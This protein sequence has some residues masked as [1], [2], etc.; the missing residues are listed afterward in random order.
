MRPQRLLSQLLLLLQPAIYVHLAAAL[1]HSIAD[2]SN[3][4][5]LQQQEDLLH[6]RRNEA[7][8][9]CHLKQINTY[10]RNNKANHVNSKDTNPGLRPSSRADGQQGP[11]WPS[12]FPVPWLPQLAVCKAEQ[13]QH[14]LVL[15]QLGVNRLA[16]VLLRFFGLLHS[17]LHLPVLLRRLRELQQPARGSSN[18][19]SSSS[20]SSSSNKSSSKSSNGWWPV[21]LQWDTTLALLRYFLSF[22]P[23]L[24]LLLSSLLLLFTFRG[25]SSSKAVAAAV[26][27]AKAVT[28]AHNSN[29]DAAYAGLLLLLPASCTRSG[30]T[31]GKRTLLLLLFLA[32]MAAAAAALAAAAADGLKVAGC[33]APLLFDAFSGLQQQAQQQQRQQQGLSGLLRGLQQLSAD[34]AAAAPAAAAAARG[35]ALSIPAPAG[36]TAAA[37]PAAA[38]AAPEVG[39]LLQE[40]AA[41]AKQLK[42]RWLAS[43]YVLLLQA[44]AKMQQQLKHQQRECLWQR[45][46]RWMVALLPLCGSSSCCSDDSNS[47]NG[48]RNSS[49]RTSSPYMA[50]HKT[51]SSDPDDASEQ[52]S[53]A[54][55]PV[56]GSVHTP[57]QQQQQ[58]DVPVGKQQQGL[59]RCGGAEELAAAAGEIG[60]VLE[61][62][63][64]QQLLLQQF[65]A[66]TLETPQQQRQQQRLLQQQQQVAAVLQQELPQLW[67]FVL[68]LLQ[69]SSSSVEGLLR[70]LPLMLLISIGVAT[71]GA[72]AA[73]IRFLASGCPEVG[74]ASSTRNQLSGGDPRDHLWAS[75]LL[76]LGIALLLLQGK[77]HAACSGCWRAFG[78]CCCIAAALLLLAA[79]VAADSAHLLQSL[80]QDE[81]VTHR[82]MCPEE[83]H[84]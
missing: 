2:S 84:P 66:D 6:V 28:Q 34:W 8:E 35:Q 19:S 70:Q 1:S 23:F 54:P 31:S 32:A 18:S 29:S 40:G 58:Q 51:S 26:Q 10:S 12:G 4:R 37:A 3:R 7:D 53:F 59:L 20:S 74:C 55:V 67:E 9:G 27:A 57:Q 77:L 73:F 45:S 80:L 79:V 21:G 17:A 38:T 49:T 82:A 25:N 75:Y 61:Q 13:R 11:S 52:F 22:L 46:K 15:R 44:E 69:V 48:S 56:P 76:G 43:R 64:Q 78:G 50:A 60:D 83:L 5:H 81:T 36:A 42:R 30:S 71:A 33:A 63:L 41:A 47:I 62:A 14:L 65:V 16:P 24:L 39:S 72:A 68:L